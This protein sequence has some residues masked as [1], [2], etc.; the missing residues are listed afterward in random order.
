MKFK[1]F[2]ETICILMIFQGCGSINNKIEDDKFP[3][4]IEQYH[5]DTNQSNNQNDVKSNSEESLE[6]WKKN[7]NELKQF[8][9]NLLRNIKNQ[10]DIDEL[11]KKEFEHE[12]QK[13]EN[14]LT[15]ANKQKLLKRFV[16]S[17]K[18]AKNWSQIESKINTINYN[19]LIHSSEELSQKYF[20]E[21][22]EKQNNNEDLD[23]Y[24][25]KLDDF[26]V[27]LEGE[28][29]AFDIVKDALQEEFEFEFLPTFFTTGAKKDY[30]LEKA[31]KIYKAALA[32]F[33]NNEL[34]PRGALFLA[35]LSFDRELFEDVVK[36]CE[37]FS[38]KYSNEDYA[39]QIYYLWANSYYQLENYEKA[40]N[41][42]Y[43]L[44]DT[45]VNSKL[46]SKSYLLISSSHLKMNQ[47][48]KAIEVYVKLLNLTQDKEIIEKTKFRIAKV[49]WIYKRW[50]IAIEK[51]ENFLKEHPKSLFK[52]EVEYMLADAYM[53]IKNWDK[54]KVIYAE[55]IDGT[56]VNPFLPH[57]YFGL[58][59]WFYRQEKPLEALQVIQVLKHKYP[60]YVDMLQVMVFEI[61][62][63]FDLKLYM[64]M[65][66]Q[67]NV[68]LQKYPKNEYS[69]E[70]LYTAGESYLNLGEWQTAYDYFKGASQRY[71][72]SQYG[73]M[74]MFRMGMALSIG[75]DIDGAM[76]AYLYAIR[77]YRD[78]VEA[79]R[80]RVELAKLWL[81][82][83]EYDKAIKLLQQVNDS[84]IVYPDADIAS[85]F[86]QA[87]IYRQLSKIDQSIEMYQSILLLYFNY[88][89]LNSNA[90]FEIAKTYENNGRKKEA[91]QFYN[92]VTQN[93]SGNIWAAQAVW[94]KMLI[95]WYDANSIERFI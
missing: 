61:R 69:A 52:F 65:Q 62:L 34:A 8:E 94:N 53:Q 67:V 81:D 57:V 50:E 2:C 63:L 3:I 22:K 6:N 95:E 17:V 51:L 58:V 13:I 26:I 15:Q 46:I 86:M 79:S 4:V 11:L 90:L 82:K 78:N 70:L 92:D 83:K 1:I 27:D 12:Y 16:S 40:I 44:I 56:D 19:D 10:V 47:T 64:A 31:E 77:R 37:N 43:K 87:D 21:W 23:T 30:Y 66:K 93:D 20:I 80:A 5:Q 36:E 60:E 73:K 18:E 29:S 72:K 28:L 55:I 54:S 75:G 14:K 9:Q 35:Q 88:K 38:Q 25:D 91:I 59:K 71:R 48:D 33:P 42:F 7:I 32:E 45:F 39:D 68:A 49:N 85:R 74:S 84:R 76:R 24:E 41:I 89:N